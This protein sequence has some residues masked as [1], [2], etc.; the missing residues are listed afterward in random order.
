[1]EQLS[2]HFLVLA[3]R[4]IPLVLLLPLGQELVSYSIKIALALVFVVSAYSVPTAA[5]VTLSLLAR[6]VMIGGMIAFPFVLVVS[7]LEM[8]GE[9]VDLGRGQMAAQ[10][11]DPFYQQN[12]PLAKLAY[13]GGVAYLLWKGVLVELLLAYHESYTRM[14]SLSAHISG[15]GP[16]ILERLLAM[17]ELLATLVVP[18]LYLFLLVELAFGVA[19][20]LFSAGKLNG[21]SFV[22]K[23]AILTLTLVVLVATGAEESLIELYQRWRVFEM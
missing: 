12:S 23:S 11:I 2:A 21:E 10:F 3:A 5:E 19:G 9:L 4:A 17:F 14:P 16:L 13:V 7:L 18:V 20:K 8:A 6:E 22:V 15:M 1:M